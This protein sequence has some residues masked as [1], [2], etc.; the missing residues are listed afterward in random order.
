[1]ADLALSKT[2]VGVFTV[3]QLGAY[4]LNV[5]NLGPNDAAGPLRV[6]DTLPAGLRFV[7]ATGA[8]WTCVQIPTTPII[9]CITP[10]GLR[11]GVSTAIVLS[12]DVDPPAVPGVTNTAEVSSATTD[13]NSANNVASDPTAVRPAADLA[14]TLSDAPDPV[15]RARTLTYT[16]Q[17]RNN[18]RSAASNIVV[19][20]T[21]ASSF[22]AATSSQGSCAQS[23]GVVT[24]ALG[25]LANGASATI[26]VTT[27]A[28]SVPGLIS[29]TARVRGNEVDLVPANNTAVQQTTVA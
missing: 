19:T 27:T 20:D 18:G 6:Q 14:V 22:V 17:V 1:V 12:V 21:I 15:L 5:N 2:H 9:R 23:S 3:G 10:A 4:T 8:G 24:C 7:T 29:S 28:P 25:G 13:P 11:R 26:T 16:V